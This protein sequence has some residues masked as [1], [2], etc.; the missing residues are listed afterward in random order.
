MRLGTVASTLSSHCNAD[1]FQLLTAVP[2]DLT[3]C[4]RMRYLTGHG[5]KFG[6]LVDPWTRAQ[7]MTVTVDG[8]RLY[9]WPVST[10]GGRQ[11]N[12]KRHLQAVPYGD[13]P[14]Q[15]GV[16]Q[17]ADAVFDLLRP[18]WRRHSRHLRSHGCVRLSRKNAATLWDLVKRENMANTT[19]LLTGTTPDA[20]PP[21]VA[22]SG[23]MPLTA[24][25]P[26]YGVPPPQ[27]QRRS[28]DYGGPMVAQTPHDLTTPMTRPTK[29]RRARS[30]SRATR[31]TIAGHCY[32][33]PFLFDR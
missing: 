27:Y 23:P 26:H 10:G 16:G 31:T 5:D 12:A 13:R 32:R 1:K 8:N 2:R 30:T 29:C 24:D 14:L 4:Q 19:G 21:A 25:D 18:E 33:C 17:R 28:D 15:Q 3:K 22:R 7:R 11:Q 6:S 9:D 20:R